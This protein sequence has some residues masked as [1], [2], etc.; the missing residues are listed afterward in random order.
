MN[1][2][3]SDRWKKFV[4][5]RLAKGRYGSESEIMDAALEL[6]QEREAQLDSL[7]KEIEAGRR[8]GKSRPYDP[9]GIKRRGR[10]RLA[11]RTK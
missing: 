10:T 5:S 3:L 7:R 9:D 1:I 11:A 2:A 8:S 4:R 6:L